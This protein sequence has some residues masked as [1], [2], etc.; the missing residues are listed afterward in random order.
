MKDLR[1]VKRADV[2]R[3]DEKVG[4]QDKVSPSTMSLPSRVAR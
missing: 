4:V 3:G 2:Y 1:T